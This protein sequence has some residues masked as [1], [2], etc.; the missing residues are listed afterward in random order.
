M[1]HMN[2]VN[3]MDFC[4]T[5]KKLSPVEKYQLLQFGDVVYLINLLRTANSNHGHSHLVFGHSHM[6]FP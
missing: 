2:F 5:S 3:A 1:M 4:T 6:V